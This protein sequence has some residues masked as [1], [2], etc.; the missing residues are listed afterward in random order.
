MN[1]KSIFTCQEYQSL[2]GNLH[3][4][5]LILEVDLVNL[6]SEQNVFINDLARY[7]IFELVQIEEV[8]ALINDGIF[9]NIEDC[10]NM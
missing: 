7:S 8:E 4:L 1:I 9:K 2:V 5:Y 3:Y 6:T 10:Y